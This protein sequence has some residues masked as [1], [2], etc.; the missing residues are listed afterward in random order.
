MGIFSFLSQK[1]N[2]ELE[3]PDD[4][5][6]ALRPEEKPTETLSGLH[7]ETPVEILGE[8]GRVV[9]RGIITKRDG[10]EITIGRRPGGLSFKRYEL[11]SSVVI[12][13]HDSNM[14]QLYFRAIVAESSRILIRL[15][16]LVQEILDDQRDA[17]RL[18]VDAPITIFCYEDEHMQLPEECTLVD[19]STGGCCISSE[20]PYVEG[21]VLRL[22]IKLDR[23]APINLVGEIIRVT[24]HGYR[25]YSYGI[26][27]AKLKKNEQDTLTRTLF[28]LQAGIRAEHNQADSYW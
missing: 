28:N 17:F 13:S 27:F 1:E 8:N 22:R 20:H 4:M 12:Q 25:D 5:P 18:T 9:I 14:A 2:Q 7:K 15:K 6:S 26:L 23:Y 19:I 3:N 16:D 11:G 10:R 21:D 24:K